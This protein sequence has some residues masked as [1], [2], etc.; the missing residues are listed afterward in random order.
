MIYS[1]KSK[2]SDNT[3]LDTRVL[4]FIWLLKIVVHIYEQEPVCVIQ[5]INYIAAFE[6]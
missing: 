6:C 4:K 5:S 1:D 3:E 2:Y